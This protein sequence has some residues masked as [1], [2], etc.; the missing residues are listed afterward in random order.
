MVYFFAYMLFCF[1]TLSKAVFEKDCFASYCT[2]KYS[3]TLSEKPCKLTAVADMSVCS[4]ELFSIVVC[5]LLQS[6][7]MQNTDICVYSEH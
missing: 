3:V 1:L 2:E 7:K 6:L 5:I 4:L